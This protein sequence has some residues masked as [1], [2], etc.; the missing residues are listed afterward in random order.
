MC[1]CVCHQFAVFR[2]K[3]RENEK[4]MKRENENKREE[5]YFE[6]LVFSAENIENVEISLELVGAIAGLERTGTRFACIPACDSSETGF[7]DGTLLA[8]LKPK[9]PCSF[10]AL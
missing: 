7:L 10:G 3:K 5:H 9:E 2:K 4:E 8:F 1:V 6:L